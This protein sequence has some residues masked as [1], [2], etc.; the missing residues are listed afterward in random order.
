MNLAWRARD[1]TC[2]L[3]FVIHT[4]KR[5]LISNHWMHKWVLYANIECHTATHTHG[6]CYSYYTIQIKRVRC[7]LHIQIYHIHASGVLYPPHFCCRVA[8][9]LCAQNCERCRLRSYF[10]GMDPILNIDDDENNNNHI[11][12]E[13][14][15]YPNTHSHT[16]SH[17]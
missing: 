2:V 16:H 5:G 3:C 1:I 8:F 6:I 10:Y 12:Y 9:F 11:F 4:S 15:P 14:I 13:R 7:L 17:T